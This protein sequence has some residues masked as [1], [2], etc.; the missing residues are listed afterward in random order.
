METVVFDSPEYVT[1]QC[2]FDNDILVSDKNLPFR[3][4]WGDF[5]KVKRDDED[6]IFIMVAIDGK[7]FL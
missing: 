7:E 3:K 2:I 5:R 4:G 6:I 1:G